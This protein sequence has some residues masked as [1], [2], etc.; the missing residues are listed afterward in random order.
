MKKPT[1]LLLCVFIFPI[2]ALCQKLS[3]EKNDLS[4]NRQS[5]KQLHKIHV[6]LKDVKPG[7]K[8]ELKTFE[9]NSGS[10]A[11]GVDYK[12]TSPVNQD[13]TDVATID[14]DV[15]EDNGQKRPKS[16]I[17]KLQIESGGETFMVLTDSLII[18]PAS[19]KPPEKGKWASQPLELKDID[20]SRF[21]I[22]TAGSLNF[23][24]NSFFSKYVG[25]LDVRMPSLHNRWGAN[26][27]VFTKSF[28]TDSVY[29]G[30]GVFN[31]KKLNDTIYYAQNTYYRFAKKEFN[32]V[33]AYFNPTYLIANNDR[34][35]ASLRIYINASFEVLWNSI[36]TTF[37]NYKLVDSVNVKY[38]DMVTREDAL[39]PKNPR[40]KPVNSFANEHYITGYYGIGP[41]LVYQKSDLLNLN[42]LFL[43]G[44]SITGGD[45]NYGPNP[46]NFYKGPIPNKFFYLAKGVVTEKVTKLNATIGVEVRGFYPNNSAMTAYLGFLISP[47]DFFK[48]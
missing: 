6:Y 20:S 31:I 28:Y 2:T 21:T 15:L 37:N 14:I 3:V 33:G 1:L 34:N 7:K 12:L 4:I 36:K 8:F 46:S 24:G 27:G 16:V 43:T 5:T 32:T 38:N 35:K 48:K 41:Q 10:A 11:R 47:A 17:F 13:I 44:G 29:T 45:N 9:T 18:K 23:F 30:R 26:A 25:Q 42:V 39:E 19:I 40:I 22:L